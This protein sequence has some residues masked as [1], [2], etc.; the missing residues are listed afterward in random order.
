L[1]E[2]DLIGKPVPT[3]PDHALGDQQLGW[4]TCWSPNCAQQ[5]LQ[6]QS[7]LLEY[8]DGGWT[9]ASASRGG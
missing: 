8:A 5:L 7:L 4:Q 1:F 2:H 3:F 6:L 9:Q